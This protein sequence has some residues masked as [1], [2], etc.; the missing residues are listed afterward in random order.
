MLVVE[1]EVSGVV[2]HCRV[3]RR[4]LERFARRAEQLIRRAVDEE[5]RTHRYTSRTG[6]LEQSTEVRGQAVGVDADLDVVM[7]ASYASY[8]DGRS[9]SGRSW[10]RFSERYSNAVLQI[11][12][13]RREMEK[14]A[15]G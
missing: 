2:D 5:K 11:D 1:V 7:A 14:A 4:L 6:H 10:S 3:N 15:G 12:A 9:K 8:L 13:E